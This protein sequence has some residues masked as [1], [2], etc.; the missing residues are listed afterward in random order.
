MRKLLL[1]MGRFDFSTHIVVRDSIEKIVAKVDGDFVIKIFQTSFK[2]RF[3]LRK[4]FY[5]FF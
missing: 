1:S 3:S 5:D 2:A 4:L